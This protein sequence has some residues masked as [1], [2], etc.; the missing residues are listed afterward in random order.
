MI[1]VRE[2]ELKVEALKDE[3]FRIGPCKEANCAHRKLN[4]NIDEKSTN[5]ANPFEMA[6][7]HKAAR[8][9]PPIYTQNPIQMK[10]RFQSLIPDVP[11]IPGIILKISENYNL[12]LQEIT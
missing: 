4:E 1:D 11:E 3:L 7:H 5:Q 6:P 8:P 10:K 2:N 12:K 9:R